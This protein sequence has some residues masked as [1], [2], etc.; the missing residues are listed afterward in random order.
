MSKGE[1]GASQCGWAARLGVCLRTTY[2]AAKCALVLPT[3][4]GVTCR[5]WRVRCVFCPTSSSRDVSVASRKS[6]RLSCS[7]LR[8]IGIDLDHYDEPPPWVERL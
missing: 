8:P 1:P 7:Q 6:G 5:K 3:L 4:S 2:G